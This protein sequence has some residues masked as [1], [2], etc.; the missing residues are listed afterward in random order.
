MQAQGQR[1]SSGIVHARMDPQLDMHDLPD[2]AKARV[3]IL[4]DGR[5]GGENR[6][7]GLA[8]MLGFKD[9]EVVTMKPQYGNKFLKL[10]PVGML[11][12]DYGRLL[13][14]TRDVDL[15]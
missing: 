3:M 15:D 8:E 10:L 1:K 6:S 2:I 13:R 4:S 12:T 7:I 11:Y 14:D 5:T 9:P